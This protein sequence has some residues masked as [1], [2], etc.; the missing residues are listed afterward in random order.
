M[1][2]PSELAITDSAYLLRKLDFPK[3][4]KLY[5]FSFMPHWRSAES[6]DF[7]QLCED[8]GIHFIDPTA[9]V[10]EVLLDILRSE[11][12]VSEAMH[13]AIVADALRVP[14]VPVRCGIHISEFKWLDWCKSLELD[15]KPY[16]LPAMYSG[17]S[18]LSELRKRRLLTES[19]SK[20]LE[21]II[22]GT[23]NMLNRAISKRTAKSLQAIVK[24]PL[25]ILSSDSKIA[26]IDSRFD[27]KLEQF[28]ADYNQK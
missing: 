22:C 24:N 16:R 25:P 28:K 8:I 6:C 27:E 4:K 10:D 7:K 18:I 9:S 17:E 13:G 15:Y 14:W 12:V 19:V 23:S 3:E 21:P 11:I 20:G 26:S 2:L 1:N 5:P